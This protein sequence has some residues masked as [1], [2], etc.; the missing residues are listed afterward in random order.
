MATSK[1]LLSNQQL[2]THLKTKLP[3]N[4]LFNNLLIGEFKAL[5]YICLFCMKTIS[6]PQI[7]EFLHNHPSWCFTTTCAVAGAH[8]QLRTRV[9]HQPT[10]GG[11][12][13]HG[14]SSVAAVTE[15]E[16]FVTE[17]AVILCFA[18][19]SLSARGP[20]VSVRRAIQQERDQKIQEKYQ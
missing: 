3:F 5:S 19:V 7:L 12:A 10:L 1:W 20:C 11:V 13:F 9:T 4:E 15:G 2:V 14:D 8:L 18:S 6:L 16:G 17:T